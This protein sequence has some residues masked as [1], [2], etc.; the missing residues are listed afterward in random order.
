M[1]GVQSRL[2]IGRSIK[3]LIIHLRGEVAQVHPAPPRVAVHTLLMT[4]TMT[5]CTPGIQ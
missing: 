1:V 5:M 3:N 2:I 4:I